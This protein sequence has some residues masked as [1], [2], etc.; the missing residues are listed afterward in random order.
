MRAGTERLWKPVSAG[1]RQRTPGAQRPER[2]QR[3]GLGVVAVLSRVVLALALILT[4]ALLES[5]LA[6]YAGG[7]GFGAGG[8]DCDA[9]R[10][11]GG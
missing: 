3:S 6:Q 2:P 1:V 5:A 8:W 4:L 9:G 10:V 7:F 11:V